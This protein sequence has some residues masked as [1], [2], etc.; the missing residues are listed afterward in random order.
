MRATVRGA[1]GRLITVSTNV[2][3]FFGTLGVFFIVV[4]GIEK[5]W[6]DLTQTSDPIFRW[7]GL[8]SLVCAPYVGFRIVTGFNA[9]AEDRD[10]N[11]A[12]YAKLYSVTSRLKTTGRTLQDA[13]ARG[14]RG[15]VVSAE[16]HWHDAVTDMEA[17]PPWWERA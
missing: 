3:L 7:V 8:L 14:S 1:L 4:S 10:A 17:V 5:L 11:K 16:L 9:L 6:Q 13:T 2:A 12:R 15:E